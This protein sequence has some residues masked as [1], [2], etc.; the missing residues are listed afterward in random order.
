M[1]VVALPG[2]EVEIKSQDLDRQ[3]VIGPGLRKDNQNSIVT[4]K[5]GFLKSKDTF[6]WIDSYQ[7]RVNNKSFF[8]V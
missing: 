5:C 1:Q 7:K 3:F 4:M 6:Y 8:F 2:D